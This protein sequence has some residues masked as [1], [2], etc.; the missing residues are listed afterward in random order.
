MFCVLQ[1]RRAP[2]CCSICGRQT[3]DDTEDA[4]AETTPTTHPCECREATAIASNADM[5][6]NDEAAATVTKSSTAGSA[7]THGRCES[8]QH[9]NGSGKH[10]VQLQRADSSTQQSPEATVVEVGFG[11]EGVEPA[12]GTVV[13]SQTLKAI[14]QELDT[15]KNEASGLERALQE[16]RSEVQRLR[17]VLATEEDTTRNQAGRLASLRY[18]TIFLDKN[19][20]WFRAVA[21]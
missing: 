14:R 4:N 13:D 18:R 3:E 2:K 6:I 19:L 16:S 1:A 15:V 12:R 17:N 10:E 9:S 21:R 11:V 7:G 20:W 5:K 8:S